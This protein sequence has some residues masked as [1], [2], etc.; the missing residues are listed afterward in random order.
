MP[1]QDAPLIEW[2]QLAMVALG[3]AI[4]A[5]NYQ[6]LLKPNQLMPPG[7]GGVVALISDWL[8]QPIGLVNVIANLPLF[9]IGFRFVGLRFLLLCLVGAGAM[10]LFLYVF[11]SVP[12]IHSWVLATVVGGVVNGAA[13]A[14]VLLFHGATGGLDIVCVILA[15]LFP[16]FSIGRLMF[17]INL[18]IV[19]IAGWS[20]GIASFLGSVISMYLAGRTIDIVMQSRQAKVL[21]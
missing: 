3:A 5:I 18:I 10:S 7:F 19:C 12:G 20:L 15:K 13:V 21:Q 11:E 4:I 8:R 6:L 1:R 2:V 16:R 17:S 9:F 14:L